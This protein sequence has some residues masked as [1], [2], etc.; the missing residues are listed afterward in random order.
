MYYYYFFYALIF[1]IFEFKLYIQT[2]KIY[3]RKINIFNFC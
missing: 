3:K 1:I 2:E